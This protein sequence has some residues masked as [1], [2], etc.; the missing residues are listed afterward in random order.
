MQQS[1]GY[2]AVQSEVGVGTTF[3]V[4]L[5]SIAGTAS[6][7][8][9]QR[10]AASV[11]GNGTILLVED[12]PALRALAVTALKNLGYTVLE[13]SSGVQAIVIAKGHLHPIDVVV[14]DVVMPHM[15][16]PASG[17]RSPSCRNP[18]LPENSPRRFRKSGRRP[19][20]LLP[21]RPRRATDGSHRISGEAFDQPEP[22]TEES[23]TARL[24]VMYFVI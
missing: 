22:A 10:T 2:V 18:S 15:S 17:P 7:S 9:A 12:E 19:P 24:D 4:Y 20:A 23:T 8:S 16:G 1:K 14:T 3:K 6:I 11:N 13:A 21:R 5:P